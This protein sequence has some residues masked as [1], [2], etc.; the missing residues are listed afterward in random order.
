MT[1]KHNQTVNLPLLAN[2][3]ALITGGGDGFGAAIARIFA[4]NG[5]NVVIADI[6]L[7]KARDITESI[8]HQAL[9]IK[10]DVT[11]ADDSINMVAQT[12]SHFGNLDIFVANAG[13]THR[14]MPMLE[15]DE[16]VF[17]LMLAVNVKALYYGLRAVVPAMK[18]GGSIITLGATVATHPQSGLVWFG[19]SKGF[20]MSATQAMAIELAPKNIRVNALCPIQAD[21]TSLTSFYGRQSQTKAQE[22]IGQIPLGRLSSPDD[23]AKAALWLASDQSSFTTGIL[24]PIDGGCM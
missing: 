17:D 2:K 7:K 20:V 8:G 21:Q 13:F 10:A 22:L 3:T 4:Q 15:V 5:A 11:R 19:A 12:Q 6:N 14:Q 9:A 24:L 1:T 23:I 18:E 16:D